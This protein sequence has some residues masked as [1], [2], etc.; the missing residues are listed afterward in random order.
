MGGTEIPKGYSAID[1]KNTKTGKIQR[2]LVPDGTTISFNGQ[3]HDPSKV[4]NKTFTIYGNPSEAG[5][6]MMGL[7]LEHMDVNN[8]GRI[9]KKDTDPNIGAKIN[10]DK[11]LPKGARID[12]LD[13]WTPDATVNKGEGYVRFTNG[14]MGKELYY[15]EIDNPK[16][17]D[18]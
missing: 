14:H 15:V 2:Y 9:D 16:T 1:F 12:Y 17:N 11:N 18:F 8:D 10:K 3:K 7:A 6:K 4:K 13:P 5:F